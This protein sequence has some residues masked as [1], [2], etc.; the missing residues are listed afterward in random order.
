[1]NP[2]PTRELTCCVVRACQLSYS[3]KERVPRMIQVYLPEDAVPISAPVVMLCLLSARALFPWSDER[4]LP[5]ESGSAAVERA[6][7]VKTS[8]SMS[9]AASSTSSAML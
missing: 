1:M 7:G 9:I 6:P 5:W 3:I 4:V 8:M 2:L